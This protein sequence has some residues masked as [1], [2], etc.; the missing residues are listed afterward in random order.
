MPRSASP[1]TRK[2][3]QG[4][5]SKLPGRVVNAGKYRKRRLNDT[6]FSQNKDNKRQRVS[7]NHNNHNQPTNVLNE[8]IELKEI[9]LT[10]QTTNDVDES[11]EVINGNNMSFVNK[12]KQCVMNKE[13]KNYR[14]QTN[15]EL[16]VMSKE[17]ARK[18]KGAYV[19]K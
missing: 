9:E 12:Y 6:S 17:G 8:D 18:K 13:W 2:S 11:S 10:P 15:M 3:K 16:E 5:K 7:N 1:K 19:G 4:R 14:F